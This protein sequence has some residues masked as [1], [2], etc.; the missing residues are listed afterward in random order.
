MEI[1]GKQL[2]CVDD[3][4][5]ID[6]LAMLQ[7]VWK[8]IEYVLSERVFDSGRTISD[9]TVENVNIVVN[10]YYM[11][12]KTAMYLCNYSDKIFEELIEGKGERG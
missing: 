6:E 5:F 11:A 10:E 12:C 1:K 9:L 8:C 4:E 3:D 2:L 7:E